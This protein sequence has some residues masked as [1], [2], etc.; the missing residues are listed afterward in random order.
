MHSESKNP[1]GWSAD[2]EPV[3]LPPRP[4]WRVVLIFVGVFFIAQY[5]WNAA[6]GGV[7][8]WVVIHS[9]TVIPAAA[10]VNLITPQIGAQAQGASIKAP[11]GGLNILNGCDGMEVA[12]LLIA[13]FLSLKLPLKPR[14]A[15]LALGLLLVFVLNQARILTLFYAFRTDRQLFDALH[16]AVLPVVLV[17]LIA[18]Y[19]YAFLH[20]R[21]TKLA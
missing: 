5:A 15:G 2:N 12:F 1:G 8:E 11:G 10:M 18:L 17:A 13:G 9:G 16:T 21:Q 3:D 20:Y 6:K 4:L 14:L 7:V 19:F